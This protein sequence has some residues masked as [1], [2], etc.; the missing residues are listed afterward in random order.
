MRGR[1]APG[2]WQAGHGLGPTPYPGRAIASV[3]S[4]ASRAR[5]GVR[6]SISRHATT[7][8]L[9]HQLGN[10]PGVVSAQ[11]TTQRVNRSRMAAR[12]NQPSRVPTYV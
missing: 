4:L 1:D 8:G 3:D 12:Y 6:F 5:S 10:E 11:P 2:Y 7:D 9:C